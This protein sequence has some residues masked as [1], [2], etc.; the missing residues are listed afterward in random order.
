MRAF[1][2]ELKITEPNLPKTVSPFQIII[3]NSPWERLGNRAPITV[4]TGMPS[5][6]PILISLSSS[7]LTQVSSIDRVSV[8]NKISVGRLLDSLDSIYKDVNVALC[9]ARKKST[10]CHYARTHVKP[11]Q[12][13]FGDY[14]PVARTG[15]PRTKM[16]SNWLASRRTVIVPSEFTVQVEHLVTE[17]IDVVHVCR[18]NLYTDE[19]VGITAD[20][21]SLAEF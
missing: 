14:F 8:M 3:Y 1:S 17:A 13:T 18:I 15:G 16:L 9:D 11:Y 5:V 6:N 4:H 10:D 19:L 2:S 7:E 21:N 12:S 20:M